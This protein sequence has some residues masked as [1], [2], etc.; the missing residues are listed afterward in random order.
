MGSPVLPGSAKSRWGGGC[1]FPPEL[2]F[3]APGYDFTWTGSVK[4][5]GGQTLAASERKGSNVKSDEGRVCAPPESRRLVLQP[6]PNEVLARGHCRLRAGSSRGKAP[7]WPALCYFY[8]TAKD[9]SFHLQTQTESPLQPG[10]ARRSLILHERTLE[11]LFL[12]RS[13]NFLS[14]G[15]KSTL[16][17]L[18]RNQES[19]LN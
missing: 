4:A 8:F 6:A 13:P 10:L 14:P 5:G 1:L 3:E 15:E 12:N 2:P 18:S 9:E 7:P 19:T 16:H 11:G 17:D